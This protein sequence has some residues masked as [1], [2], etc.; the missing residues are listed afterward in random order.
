M[1]FS[2][3]QEV[4][5]GSSLPTD[6]VKYKRANVECTVNGCKN[7]ILV[8]EDN[9]DVKNKRWIT[10][11]RIL[12]YIFK[13]NSILLFTLLLQKVDSIM[14]QKGNAENDEWTTERVKLGSLQTILDLY[15]D[16]SNISFREEEL[17][18]FFINFFQVQE[19]DLPTLYVVHRPFFSEDG[20]KKIMYF[21]YHFSLRYGNDPRKTADE[22][23]E[24]RKKYLEVLSKTINVQ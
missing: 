21:E 9:E 24:V 2:K 18:S 3:F 12:K 23:L 13:H 8:C 19:T 6:T 1:E 17:L 16:V 10:S 20:W 15:R 14:C 5:K 22:D 11:G 7:G 4:L